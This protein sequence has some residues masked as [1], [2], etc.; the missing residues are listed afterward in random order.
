[1]PLMPAYECMKSPAMWNSQHYLDS[2]QSKK[3]V[4]IY[5][6]TIIRTR[7]LSIIMII[8]LASYRGEKLLFIASRDNW[9][10]KI[11]YSKTLYV[12]F[13]RPNLLSASL[14]NDFVNLEERRVLQLITA[15]LIRRERFEGVISGKRHLLSN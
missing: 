5:Q 10:E 13:N 8:I 4:T 3:N 11:C 14:Y 6:S 12:N 1:M 2:R 9:H 15:L 7:A